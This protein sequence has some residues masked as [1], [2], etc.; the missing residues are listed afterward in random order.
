MGVVYPRTS[1]AI[2]PKPT[3]TATGSIVVAQCVRPRRK[4]D[5]SDQLHV[6]I[7][8]KLKACL[9]SLRWMGYVYEGAR[10]DVND[11]GGGELSITLKRS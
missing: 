10:M 7:A 8:N 5:D 1:C 9:R 6:E 3:E 11:G 2:Y 4:H